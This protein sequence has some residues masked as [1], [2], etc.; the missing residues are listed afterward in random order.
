MEIYTYINM[1]VNKYVSY[2]KY[3]ISMNLE[4]DTHWRKWI[5]VLKDSSSNLLNI[6]VVF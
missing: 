3:V 5:N 1:F 6:L 2:N 4:I